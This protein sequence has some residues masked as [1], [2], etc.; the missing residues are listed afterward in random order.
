[1][2]ALPIIYPGLHQPSDADQVT[3]C[4]ISM[5]RLEHRR[6]GFTVG[7]WILDSGAFTR[8]TSGKGHLPAIAYADLAV[9]WQTNG[10]CEA[11]V[12]QD[13]MCEPIALTVTGLTV[14]DHQL[15]TLDRFLEVRQLA[16][17]VRWMPVLQGFTPDDYRHHAQRLR[18]WI[19]T[20]ARVGVGSVC[21]RQTDFE[22]L[23]RVLEAIKDVAPEWKLHG[24]GVKST[25]LRFGAI[26]DL[27]WSV[28]SMAWSFAA[29]REGRNA[30]NIS[31]CL[32]W[33][34]RVENIEPVW[35]GRFPAV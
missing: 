2:A 22:E 32:R 33:L 9:R 25:A 7:D 31:E 35:Q 16:P 29:R 4:M 21:K 19:S 34:G 24:F 30:N 27:L 11:V 15:L 20:N 3:R 12:Q 6:S 5:N 1:M 26:C 13:W 17:L 18:P 8:I 28:D 10:N 14:R 23:R